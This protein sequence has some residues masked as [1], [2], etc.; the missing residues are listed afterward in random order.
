MSKA[1]GKSKCTDPGLGQPFYEGFGT[2]CPNN[3]LNVVWTREMEVWN[4]DHKM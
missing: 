1:L 4:C 3:S 2:N